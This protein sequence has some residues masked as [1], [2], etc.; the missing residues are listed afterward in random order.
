MPLMCGDCVCGNT[1]P[2]PKSAAIVCLDCTAGSCWPCTLHA[3]WTMERTACCAV[4]SVLFVSTEQGL[5]RTQDG[6]ADQRLLPVV[7]SKP[8]QASTCIPK[9]AAAV[10]CTMQRRVDEQTYCPLLPAVIAQ[11]RSVMIAARSSV[12]TG[13]IS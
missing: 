1:P 11:H 2:P 6:C 8:S 4:T 5:Y 7:A 12:C 13:R 9:A 10:I 3:G